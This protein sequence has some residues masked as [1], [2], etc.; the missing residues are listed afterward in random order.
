MISEYRTYGAIIEVSDTTLAYDRDVKLPRY[1]RAGVPEVW[2]V[3]LEGRGVESHSDP[4]AE[5]YRSRASSALA[6]R[7]TPRPWRAS[8]CR[9]AR[10]LV[11]PLLSGPS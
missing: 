4:S 2:I 3:D 7:L 9:W 8:R 6:S 5:D 10:S 1:A 11:R